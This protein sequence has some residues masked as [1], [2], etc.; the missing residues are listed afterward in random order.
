M[1]IIGVSGGFGHEAS[2]TLIVDGKIELIVEEERLSRRKY[3]REEAATR[4][5]L[6]CLRRF[7]LAPRDLDALA[8]SW[9]SSLD[10]S[11]DRMIAADRALAAAR[12]E[13]GLD[14]TPAFVFDHHRC[15][16]VTGQYM[17]GTAERCVVVVM[18]GRGENAST[19]VYLVGG[20]EDEDVVA[21]SPL[22][23]SLGTLFAAVTTYCGFGYGGQGK[24]MGLAAFG[25]PR[26]DF[27]ELSPDG[28]GFRC[29]LPA[30]GD[31]TAGHRA[32]YRQW[33]DICAE[34]FG[35]PRRPALSLSDRLR[36]LRSGD[37]APHHADAAASVQ[38]MVEARIETLVRRLA[39]EYPGLPVVL[40][41]GVALNCSANGRLRRVLPDVD[42]RYLPTPQDAGV[43]VGAAVLAARRLGEATRLPAGPYQGLGWSDAELADLLRRYGIGYH[44]PPDLAAE[45]AD[46]L[47]AGE[48]IGWFQGRAEVGP[49]A[50]GHRSILASPLDA[51]VVDRLNLEIKQREAWRP[52]GPSL[53]PDAMDKW[54]P[55][56]DAP[57]MIEAHEV[58]DAAML[59]AVVHVD[60]TSR[61][62]C[63]DDRVCSPRYV[64]VL[65]AMRRRTGHGVVLNTSFNIDGEP[66][67]YTPDDALRT[68]F[69][70][71]LDGLALGP[72]LLHRSG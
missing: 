27:P 52:F 32:V 38:A 59:P 34:V 16:A 62:H 45:V 60:G 11:N 48:V 67:V 36:P 57:F 56:A 10:P 4:S 18:D 7:D 23:A 28:L 5:V 64:A 31:P 44:E 46:R 12:G 66:I 37:F 13:L 30:P 43:S 33:N 19:T 17:S 26:H 39:S 8:I 49:R 47:L 72:F 15:H 2:A 61:P 24:T 68:Y 22:T 65:E 14:D 40:A 70:S 9:D 29:S 54:F 42:L 20:G 41:G 1:R 63:V 55:V 35:P 58:R 71:T 25:T 50:L 6:A 53:L 3:A 69:S 21:A 51:A